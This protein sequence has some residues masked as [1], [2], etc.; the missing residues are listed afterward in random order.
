MAP[1]TSS[2]RY[3]RSPSMSAGSVRSAVAQRPDLHAA[4]LRV[5]GGFEDEVVQQSV[6]RD[7]R[8]A[9]QGVVALR[10]VKRPPASV[11]MSESAAKSQMFA[12][13]VQPMSAVPRATA[14]CD[15]ELPT[16][17]CVPAPTGEGDEP[18]RLPRDD[19]TADGGVGDERLRDLRD[20]RHMDLASVQEG[21]AAP[22]GRKRRRIAGADATAT[23]DSPSRCR[24]MSV[25]HVSL[26]RTKLRVPSIGS[27]IQRQV[28]S[29]SPTTPNS[30]PMIA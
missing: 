21:A 19:E 29:R 20:L 3:A 30:S 9:E 10:S 8:A 27:M 2:R 12:R 25:A 22:G 5:A 26:P 18:F 13:D 28:A 17:A 14:R 16:P 23:T 6:R 1:S 4:R 7:A 15:I 24:A 11:T